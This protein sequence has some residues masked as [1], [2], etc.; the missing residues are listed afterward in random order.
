MQSN[1]A[2]WN[3]TETNY[4]LRPAGEIFFSESRI[5]ETYNKHL[6]KFLGF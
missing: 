1:R 2:G 6:F 3:E 5:L 4:T